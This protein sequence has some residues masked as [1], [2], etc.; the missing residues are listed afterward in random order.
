M[1]IVDIPRIA[2]WFVPGAVIPTDPTAAPATERLQAVRTNYGSSVASFLQG[3]L[4]IC[5]NTF[6]GNKAR[7]TICLQF[8][9]THR[10]GSRWTV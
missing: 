5:Q 1:K 2:P 3:S 10:N 6:L 8:R 4:S 7:H 9:N